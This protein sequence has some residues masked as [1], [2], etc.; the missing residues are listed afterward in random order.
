MTL[1]SLVVLPS[2][3][4]TTYAIWGL[5]SLGAAITRKLHGRI[6]RRYWRTLHTRTCRTE[7]CKGRVWERVTR[8]FDPD[9]GH[10][11][12]REETCPACK[13]DANNVIEIDFD[14]SSFRDDVRALDRE[15]TISGAL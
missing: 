1:D 3:I 13:L 5:A 14:S 12:D 2:V 6:E 9:K 8:E 10:V 15:H 11:Y 4:G 7:A